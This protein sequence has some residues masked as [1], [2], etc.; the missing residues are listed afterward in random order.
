MDLSSRFASD[1]EPLCR[2]YLGG[3]SVQGGPPPAQQVQWRQVSYRQGTIRLPSGWRVTGTNAQGAVDATCPDGSGVSLGIYF[4]VFSALQGPY[5]LKAP[6]MGPVQAVK[7]LTPRILAQ[8]HVVVNDLRILEAAPAGWYTPVPRG[9]AAMIVWQSDVT[10]GGKRLRFKGLSLVL[11]API[12][13]SQWMYYYSTVHA[14]A[15]SFDRMLPV[16]ME[17]WYSWKIDDAVF[18]RRL[19]SAAQSLRTVQKI[20]QDAAGYRE[21]TASN[22]SA[23]WSNVI[24]GSWPVGD[25]VDGKRESVSNAR[26]KNVIEKLNTNAGYQRYREIPLSELT[27]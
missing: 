12:D 5:P 3:E 24:R 1:F 18:R 15:E 10:A 6:Y 8:S 4:P 20:Y 17:I 27:R 13:Y 26:I 11:T 9:Q 16:L 21:R 22:A 7:V 25:S 19:R 2:T 23:A 14:P